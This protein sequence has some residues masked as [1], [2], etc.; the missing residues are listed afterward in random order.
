MKITAT[1]SKTGD[2]LSLNG[3]EIT[4]DGLTIPLDNPPVY[5]T[6]ENADIHAFMDANPVYVDQNGDVLIRLK[7][8]NE[9]F[10][11]FVNNNYLLF[12]DTDLNGDID[13]SELEALVN[14]YNLSEEERRT[15]R[16]NI[17]AGYSV[18]D[19]KARMESVKA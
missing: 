10:F 6:D 2:E 11:D 1:L 5:P 4:I 18:E 16:A 3:N 12:F 14:H 9:H 17:K 8:D 13:L 15:N 7:V 19:W